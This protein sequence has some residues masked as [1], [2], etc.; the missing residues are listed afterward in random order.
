M[1]LKRARQRRTR[2]P[3]FS[4]RAPL[5]PLFNRLLVKVSLKIIDYEMKCFF[6]FEIFLPS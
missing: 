1:T 5:P 3:T 6:F 2:M 4:L